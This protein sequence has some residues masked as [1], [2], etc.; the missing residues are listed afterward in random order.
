[1]V[2]RT[3]WIR[4]N[5]SSLSG[6][7][8]D[9]GAPDAGLDVLSV[10]AAP[11]TGAMETGATDTGTMETGAG[12]AGGCPGVGGGYHD[13][14][15]PSCWS[16]F[17]LAPF[18]Q[19]EQWY[20]GAFDGRYVYLAPSSGGIIAR[21]DSTAPFT[22]ASSWST[23]DTTSVAAAA[24]AYG[25]VTYDGRYLYFVPNGSATT[26]VVVRYD[27]K[28]SFTS[29]ASYT[30]FDL[31]SINAS[32]VVFTGGVYDGRYITFVGTGTTAGVFFARY[33][34]HAPFGTASSY[35]VYNSA[36]VNPQGLGYMGG[37]YD[38]HY[39]YFV[40][41]TGSVALRVDPTQSF[42]V[43][44][45]WTSFDASTANANA[46]SFAGGA[47]DGRY[48]YLA[49]Y[50]TAF[51]GYAAAY[52]TH[53]TFTAKSSWSV[54]NLANVDP[55]LP[56]FTGGAYDGRFV[57]FVPSQAGSMG[58]NGYV[59]RYDTSAGGLPS[60]TAWSAFDLTKINQNAPG[61]AGAVFDGRH[62]YLVPSTSACV[63]CSATLVLQ[64]DAKDQGGVPSL[65]SFYG[66]FL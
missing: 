59:A 15:S 62:L 19:R 55:D 61:Y 12:D 45:S 33:D 24:M 2:G 35:E 58:T 6:G 65:P 40:P 31:T 38:G 64:F 13:I 32:A 46:T 66:S 28:A 21:V 41:S 4:A 48:V 56:A 34:T 14:T 23:F 8:S 27:T 42:S 17:D 25:G 29:T 53:A 36:P 50:Q 11:E 52:D 51:A 5:L 26:S 16:S 20:G 1:M 43:A 57:Y 10:D 49:P 7:G 9:S 30:T 47:F 60:S 54:F 37:V 63:S 44:S 22:S 3:L 39:V 18:A